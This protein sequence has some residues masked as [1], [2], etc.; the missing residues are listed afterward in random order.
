MSVWR[1]CGCEWDR[2]GGVWGSGRAR[3]LR[4]GAGWRQRDVPGLRVGLPVWYGGSARCICTY[5]K[6]VRLWSRCPVSDTCMYAQTRAP[7]PV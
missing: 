1:T 3:V 5:A 7:F 2:G 6:Q 4:R